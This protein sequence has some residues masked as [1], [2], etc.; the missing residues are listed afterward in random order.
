MSCTCKRLSP[1][2]RGMRGFT[3]AMTSPAFFAAALTM[4]TEMP[5]L[6]SPR[7]SGGE[8]WIRAASSPICPV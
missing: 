7:S 2:V 3:C 1:R 5:R 8:T 6:H 4:S